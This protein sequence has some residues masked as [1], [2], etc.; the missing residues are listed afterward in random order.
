METAVQVLNA[1]GEQRKTSVTRKCEPALLM[2]DLV[3]FLVNGAHERP[4]YLHFVL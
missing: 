2:H 3:P 4:K 1:P